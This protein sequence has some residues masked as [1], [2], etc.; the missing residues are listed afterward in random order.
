MLLETVAWTFFAVGGSVVF[1]VAELPVFFLRFAFRD[2]FRF[3]GRRRRS[4][5]VARRR[6][7]VDCRRGW[8]LD[9]DDGF[10]DIG[11]VTIIVTY[12]VA[13]DAGGSVAADAG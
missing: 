1:V 11:T 3:D 13:A 10:F 6:N 8:P 7:V 4:R 9:A 12:A 2:L 5:T